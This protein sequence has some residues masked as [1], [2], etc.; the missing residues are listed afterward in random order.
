MRR[1]SLISDVL[2]SIGYDDG[3]L[4]AEF[5]TGAVYEYEDVPEDE[6]DGLMN[7]ESHGQYFNARIRDRYRY[8][9]LS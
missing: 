5:T 9:R 4:E 6:Y 1:I 8:R 7:A 3:R 2:R